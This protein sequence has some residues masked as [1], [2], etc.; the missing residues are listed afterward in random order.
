MNGMKK[1]VVVTGAYNVGK[2]GGDGVRKDARDAPDEPPFEGQLAAVGAALLG[3]ASP[4]AG[5]DAGKAVLRKIQGYRAQDRE[6]RGGLP[7]GDLTL[8]GVLGS[9]LACKLACYYCK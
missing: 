7:P 5:W 3:H 1:T 9:L 2:L 6:K 8:D 4:H